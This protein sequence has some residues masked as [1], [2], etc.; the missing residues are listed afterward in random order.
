MN[1]PF[2]TPQADR[3]RFLLGAALSGGALIVGWVDADAATATPAV[4]PFGPFVKIRPDGDVVVVNK[5]QEMGQG[6]HVGVCALVA[7]ELDADWARVSFEHAPANEA[8]YKNFA[9]GIQATGGSSAIANSYMQMRTAGAAVRA[10]FVQAAARRWKVPEGEITVKDSVV[11]HGARHADFRELVAAAARIPPPQKPALKDPK[12][13]TLVGTERPR[14][15]DTLAKTTG[16]IRYTQDVQG[17][18]LLVAMVAHSPRFGGKVASFDDTAARQVPGVVEVVQVP[19]G[20]AVLADTTYAAR[21]GR[22]ALKVSWDDAAAEKRSTADIFAEYR[23]MA[24]GPAGGVPF[25]NRGKAEG[26]FSGDLF[27]ASYDFPYLAHAAMEPMNCSVVLQGDRAKLTYGCQGQGWDQ[28]NVAKALGVPRDNIEIETLYAGGSF[29][30]RSTLTS[31]Y[32]VECVEVAK[33]AAAK[34]QALQGRPV[35]LVW[36]REDDMCAGKYRPMVHHAIAI[37]TDKDGYPLA[38]RHRIVCQRIFDFPGQKYDPMAT[39]G[40]EGSPYLKATPVTDTLVYAAQS[41]VPVSFW[42]SVGATHTA[43]AMEHTVDQLAR[44]AGKD[45][46]EYRRE[47]YRRAGADRHLKVLDLVIAK[48]DW[49]KAAP[50]G[51]TRVIAVHESFGSVVAQVADVTFRDGKPRVLK[52][53]SA[54]DCGVAVTPDQIRAQMESGVCYGLAGALYGQVSLKDGLVQQKNFDAYRV[55]RMDEAPLV[56]THILPSDSAP[57]GIGEPGTPLM[58][59][60]VAAAVLKTTGKPTTSLPFVTA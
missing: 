34:R 13:F 29:G 7:E 5:H 16:K 19:T 42:R 48:S 35:K 2:K 10:M 32:T 60:L 56:E 59:P 46:A 41:P 43:M 25:E 22:D 4:G 6:N 8:L 1:A 9:L 54:V 37:R 40:V 28:P 47:L 58:A 26:A 18:G 44:R 27:E 57:S 49:G 45:P 14:R 20:V 21:K 52:V 50:E 17:P 51:V 11:S 36:T 12:A 30:R 33:A 55:L 23:Q 3:R 24:Q 31:D 53:V 38:W 15:K 39:E